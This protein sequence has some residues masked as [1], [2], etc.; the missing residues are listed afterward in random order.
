MSHRLRFYADFA[1]LQAEQRRHEMEQS[2][3]EELAEREAEIQQEA[4]E[5]ALRRVRRSMPGA[6]NE[7]ISRP[8]SRLTNSAARGSAAAAHRFTL[9][10]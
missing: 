10:S 6:G 1:A 7:S 5:E 8:S 9:S 2:L 4:E 3:N